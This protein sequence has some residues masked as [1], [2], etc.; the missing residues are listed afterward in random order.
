MTIR[1]RYHGYSEDLSHP[2]DRRRIGIL[3]KDKDFEIVAPNTGKFDVTVL[4]S[5][6]NFSRYLPSESNA[7]VVIDLIDGYLAQKNNVMQDYARNFLRSFNGKSRYFDLKYSSHIKKNLSLAHGSVVPSIE[8][9]NQ[10]IKYSR[11]IDIILDNHSELL[12]IRYNP[13]ASGI[14]WEGFGSNLK[15]LQECSEDLTKILNEFDM[16]LYVLSEESFFR[17]GN[18]IGKIETSEYLKELF[19]SVYHKVKFQMWNVENLKAIAEDCK[20]AIIPINTGDTFGRSKCENKLLAMWT[21]G[22]PTLTSDTPAYQRVM[23]EASQENSSVS[24]GGWQSALAK[25]LG[26]EEILENMRSSGVNY[27]LENHQES[28][29]I[30]KWRAAITSYLE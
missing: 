20:L 28:Q 12:P 8:I 14:L 13:K 18:K 23:K 17:F 27:V 22:L 7:P 24:C 5:N 4:S 9:K 3:Q 25:V 10:A 6:A 29:L 16:R 2:G 21:L 30:E 1:I 11:N 15:H 19:P 26:N